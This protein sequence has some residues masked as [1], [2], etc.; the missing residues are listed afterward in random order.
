VVLV[1]PRSLPFTS[2]GK[3]SRAGAKALLVSGEIFAGIS[4]KL[5]PP[6]R[7]HTG[8]LTEGVAAEA[9]E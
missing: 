9:A 3:L 5:A 7:M 6:A 8:S 1:P 4:S 2:S